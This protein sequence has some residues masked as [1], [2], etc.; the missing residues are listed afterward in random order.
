MGQVPGRAVGSA[1]SRVSWSI[2][3]RFQR[4]LRRLG[5]VDSQVTSMEEFEQIN[6]TG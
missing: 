2:S 1:D 3:G 4:R 6:L 5:V